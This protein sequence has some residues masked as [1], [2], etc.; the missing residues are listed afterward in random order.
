MVRILLIGTV[1]IMVLGGL[2]YWRF[3]AVSPETGKQSGLPSQLKSI[4]PGPKEV[5]NIPPLEV[6]ENTLSDLQSQI[7]SLK[8]QVDSLKQD[9]DLDSRV[10][11][12][13]TAIADIRTQVVSL[14]AKSTSS[15]ATTTTTTTSSKYPLYIPLGGG[16]GPWGNQAYYSLDDYQINIDPGNYSGYISMQLEVIFRLAENAGTAYVRLLNATDNAAV[17]NSEVTSTGTDFVLKTSGIFTLT[18]GS[19]NYKLQVK[20]TEG[21]SLFVQNAK[22]KVNF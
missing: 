11:T 5:P 7:D 17:S 18:G 16:G 15:T 13:E 22:I 2:F 1:M 9:G 4:V 19:K 21:K 6:G 14:S 20:N 8:E 12:L 3:I 10:K